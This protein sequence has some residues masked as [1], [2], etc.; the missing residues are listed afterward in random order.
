[1]ANA[2]GGVKREHSN[3]VN[4]HNQLQHKLKTHRKRVRASF[5]PNITI[6]SIQ[7][8]QK[9]IPITLNTYNSNHL[10]KNTFEPIIL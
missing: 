4:M 2:T 10:K 5:Y 3:F 1:M 6:I 8:K 9:N 7:K